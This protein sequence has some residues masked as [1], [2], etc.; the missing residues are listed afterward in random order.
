MT[1]GCWCRPRERSLERATERPR[2]RLAA[3]ARPGASGVCAGE[4]CSWQ[5]RWDDP[6]REH[7]TLYCAARPETCL[8]EVL[9]DLR[10]NTKML[11]ELAELM[12]ESPELLQA[13]GAVEPSWR[14]LHALQA[15]RPVLDGELADVE[16][17]G[18]RSG[19]AV[20]LRA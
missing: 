13:A 12:G 3:R 2:V 8:V 1:C 19:R 17:L 4:L 15:A 11:A 5:Q 18:L 7:R 16:A 20:R 9:A 6:R 14:A 10:P